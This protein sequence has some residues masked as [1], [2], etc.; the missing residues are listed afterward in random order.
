MA[1]IEID[2]GDRNSIAAALRDGLATPKTM[3]AW[4]AEIEEEIEYRE[5]LATA[6]A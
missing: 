1:K 2:S 6:R 4:L 3:A 5:E